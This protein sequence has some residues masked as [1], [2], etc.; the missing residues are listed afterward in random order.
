MPIS[1]SIR[2]AAL[3]QASVLFDTS[4][5]FVKTGWTIHSKPQTT[6]PALLNAQCLNIVVQTFAA[7][8]ITI[9]MIS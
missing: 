1:T 5:S 2:P 6:K 9:D 8:I 7:R 3:T 4:A